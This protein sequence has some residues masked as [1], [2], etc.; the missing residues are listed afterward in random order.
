MPAS[1]KIRARRRGGPARSR[2]H[3]HR[4]ICAVGRSVLLGDRFVLLGEEMRGIPAAARS[5]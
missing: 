5:G 4:V 3:L 1:A 2:G